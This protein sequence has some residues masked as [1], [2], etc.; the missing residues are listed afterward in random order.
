MESSRGRG[1]AGPENS[2]FLNLHPRVPS[3]LGSQMEIWVGKKKVFRCWLWA[4]SLWFV[5]Q[6]WAAEPDGQEQ[7]EAH[8]NI[9][10][11]AHTSRTQTLS[12]TSLARLP[13]ESCSSV[14]P[15]PNA[16]AETQPLQPLDSSSDQILRVLFCGPCGILFLFGG[17]YLC[18]SLT[19]SLFL[20]QD[21]SELLRCCFSSCQEPAAFP[22]YSPGSVLLS[23]HCS[24]GPRH[25]SAGCRFFLHVPHS[26]KEKMTGE[27]RFFWVWNSKGGLPA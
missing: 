24:T 19:I 25:H 14:V 23:S 3:R 7:Q 9:T 16:V 1:P 12:P 22:L 10:I 8:Y 21:H 6:K 11:P 20:P 17:L 4:V 5:Q 2:S 13:R 26:I 15:I 18:S 27:K